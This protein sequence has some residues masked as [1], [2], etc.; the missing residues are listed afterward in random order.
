MNSRVVLVVTEGLRGVDVL[1]DIVV[2][3]VDAL[4]VSGFRGIK[5]VHG[6][7]IDGFKGVNVFV[8]KNNSGKSTLLEALYLVCTGNRADVLGRVPLIYIVKRRGWYGISSLEGLVYSQFT[9][10]VIDAKSNGRSVRVEIQPQVNT[11]LYRVH[12]SYRGETIDISIRFEENGRYLPIAGVAGVKS[13]VIF[14]DWN[15]MREYG[16]PEDVYSFL[17][18]AG[19]VEAEEY[20]VKTLSSTYKELR[21]FKPLKSDNKWV[22]HAILREY[23]VPFYLLGDGVRAAFT[24]LALLASVKRGV[25]LAEEP[26]LHQHTT[27]LEIIAEALIRSSFEHKNQVFI[28]THSLEFIDLLLESAEKHSLKDELVVFR[29][30]LKNGVLYYRRYTFSEALESRRELEFDLRG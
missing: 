21:G 4:R 8:G 12:D 24:Y 1:S 16:I 22:L 6:R 13:S 17:L 10:A 25:V 18:E 30:R 29:V 2:G 28:S 20:V 7:Y 3:G 27:S 19:G 23:S 9:R 26:E 11:I 14:V 5:D 15:L